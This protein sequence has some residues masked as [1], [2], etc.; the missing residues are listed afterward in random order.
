MDNDGVQKEL[1]QMEI[2]FFRQLV[3][4]TVITTTIINN[5][6]NNLIIKAFKHFIIINCISYSL[7]HYFYFTIQLVVHLYLLIFEG[8]NR[9]SLYLLLKINFLLPK[10]LH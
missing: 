1:N 10:V 6:F 5:H 3:F 8:F 9:I 7:N 4:S 2:I